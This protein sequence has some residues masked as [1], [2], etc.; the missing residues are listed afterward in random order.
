[1]IRGFF[2]IFFFFLTILVGLSGLRLTWSRKYW[3]GRYRSVLVHPSTPLQMKLTALFYSTTNSFLTHFSVGCTESLS[4]GGRGSR[5][6][7]R[8]GW[9]FVLVQ[10]LLLVRPLLR[11]RDFR[12]PVRRVRSL[13]L[14]RRS[15]S[16]CVR[17]RGMSWQAVDQVSLGRVRG[18]LSVKGSR[19][20]SPTLL[21]STSVVSVPHVEGPLDT[22]RPESCRGWPGSMSFR[23]LRGNSLVTLW[24]TKLIDKEERLYVRGILV[25]GRIKRIYRIGSCIWF[26]TTITTILTHTEPNWT[27]MRV[28]H[29]LISDVNFRPDGESWEFFTIDNYCYYVYSHMFQSEKLIFICFFWFRNVDVIGHVIGESTEGVFV[30]VFKEFWSKKFPEENEI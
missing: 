13:K 28:H 16:Q 25:F 10:W 11:E 9:G 30:F 17:Y 2:Y 1:M 4:R 27:L 29:S 12:F 19:W 18:F 24:L 7:L 3:V 21:A 6:P 14:V 8:W 5:S 15:V 26:R 22:R 20:S 23:R